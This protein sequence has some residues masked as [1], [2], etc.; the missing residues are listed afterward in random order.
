MKGEFLLEIGFEELPARHCSTILSQLNPEVLQNLAV[1]YNLMFTKPRLF[2]T[3]RRLALL[4]ESVQFKETSKEIKGPLH[5]VAYTKEKPNVIAEKFAQ[6][7]NIDIKDLKTKTINGKKFVV[8]SKDLSDEFNANIQN[9][10]D[11]M[12]STITIDKPMR[13]D[14]SGLKF[15]RPIRWLL[16][17][18]GKERVDLMLGNV[19]SENKTSGPR[20]LGSKPI[21]ISN[22]KEYEDVLAKN[23]IIVDHEKRKLLIKGVLKRLG[24]ENNLIAHDPKDELLN[25]VIFLTEY[26]QPFICAFRKEFLSLPAEVISTVA[27]RVFWV[28]LVV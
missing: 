16:C 3:P 13:W 25:E 18:C 5:D 1:K 8:A 17:L 12:V 20:F 15:S 21:G 11:E 27:C 28:R 23:K 9:F 24:K 4:S 19:I 10:L 26:P 14:K 7:Q 2:M 22:A 6:S